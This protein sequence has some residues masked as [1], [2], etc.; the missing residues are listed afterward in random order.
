MPLLTPS[1]HIQSVPPSPLKAEFTNTPPLGVKT[2]PVI[3]AARELQFDEDHQLGDK[4][5]DQE[6]KINQSQPLI[7]KSVPKKDQSDVKSQKVSEG[8]RSDQGEGQKTPVRNGSFS[9]FEDSLKGTSVYFV[10]L[11]IFFICCCKCYVSLT[12]LKSQSDSC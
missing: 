1:S 2:L 9:M 11:K 5:V 12:N 10:L 6:F 7:L 4:Q 3:N 8:Q